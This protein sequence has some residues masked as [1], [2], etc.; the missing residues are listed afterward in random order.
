MLRLSLANAVFL[1]L[2]LVGP[3]LVA[4][5]GPVEGPVRVPPRLIEFVAAEHPPG[6]EDRSEEA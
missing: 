4:G 2:L 1:A 3:A 6:L 5:Q